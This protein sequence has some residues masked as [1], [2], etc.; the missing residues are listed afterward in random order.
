MA[1]KLAGK[2]KKGE[3]FLAMVMD[4]RPYNSWVKITKVELLRFYNSSIASW[5]WVYKIFYTPLSGSLKGKEIY[6][7]FEEKYPLI[8][9]DKP[10]RLVR[11]YRIL[12][13][14]KGH[15]L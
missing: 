2:F 12:F 8:I 11:I 3:Q 13:K 5:T 9:P 4:K 7:L 1:E 15:L 6:S 14:E 10:G